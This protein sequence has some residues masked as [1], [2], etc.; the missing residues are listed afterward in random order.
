MREMSHS[1]V[2]CDSGAVVTCHESRCHEG[3]ISAISPAPPPPSDQAATQKPSFTGAGE[4][5]AGPRCP[6][7]SPVSPGPHYPVVT[8][9]HSFLFAL[10]KQFLGLGNKKFS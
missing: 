7:Q 3:P 5:R 8:G 10:Y 9:A 2:R 6:H 4:K 1:D